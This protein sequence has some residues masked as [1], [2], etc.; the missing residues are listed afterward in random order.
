MFSFLRDTKGLT[1]VEVVV[2]I[3]LI[4]IV[5]VSVVATVVQSATFS[6]RIDKVYTASYL[7]Q[8]RIDLLKRFDFDEVPNAEETDIRIGADGTVDP[9]GDYIR[10][11]G[12]YTDSNPYLLKIK[13]SVDL[14]IDG[15]PSGSPVVMET[16]F[17]DSDEDMIYMHGE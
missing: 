17:V 11:T 7:A 15:S 9:D 1:L 16:Y 5:I 13:V 8:R 12:V 6:N 2:T 10:T 3:A 4:A 14:V